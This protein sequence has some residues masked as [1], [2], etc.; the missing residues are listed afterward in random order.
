MDAT[1][2]PGPGERTEAE[3]RLTAR[4]DELA[5]AVG[6]PAPPIEAGPRISYS[7]CVICSSP[8]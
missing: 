7:G 8:V 2:W 3:A 6:L 4:L 5:R 1:R